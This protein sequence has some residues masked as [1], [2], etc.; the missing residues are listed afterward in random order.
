MKGNTGTRK[1]LTHDSRGINK[2]IFIFAF[3]LVLSFFF[4]YLNS[5][6]KEVEATIRY[7]LRFTNIPSG[8]EITESDPSRIILY[9]KGTGSSVIRQKLSSRKNPLSI[10]MSKVNYRKL[11]GNKATRYYVISGTLVRSFDVQL[12]SEFEIISVKPDTLFF[13]LEKSA[14]EQ[15]PKKSLFG[16]RKNVERD[17]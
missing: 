8:K 17:E 9:L 6:G 16:R 7:P 5:L 4:W 10:D 2:D 14:S 1:K 13:S 15:S 3:F 12:R 11:T